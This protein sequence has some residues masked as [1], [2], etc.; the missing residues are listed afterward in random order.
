MTHTHNQ[1]HTSS[2]RNQVPVPA[3]IQRLVLAVMNPVSKV[4]A[5]AIHV[6]ATT[7]HAAWT[8]DRIAGLSNHWTGRRNMV[9]ESTWTCVWTPMALWFRLLVG[10]VYRIILVVR[11]DHAGHQAAERKTRREAGE[12][13]WT[14]LHDLRLVLRAAKDQARQAFPKPVK[15]RAP[16]STVN[17]HALS[18][19]EMHEI[20][21]QHNMAIP[22]A[23]TQKAISL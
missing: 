15:R 23:P 17:V 6:D 4:E 19:K 12:V 3:W 10:L 7:S 20:L 16:A 22:V 18:E 21:K 9:S 5:K 1:N 11:Q 14:S 13:K 2:S 8:L